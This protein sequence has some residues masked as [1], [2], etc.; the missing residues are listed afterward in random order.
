VTVI[1]KQ[2]SARQSC[3]SHKE[4]TSCTIGLVVGTEA[5]IFIFFGQNGP[6]MT[7]CTGTGGVDT[8]DMDGCHWLDSSI[9]FTGQE[10]WFN[11]GQSSAAASHWRV[12]IF[13]FRAH[14]QVREARSPPL[15]L[16]AGSPLAQVAHHSTSSI[17]CAFALIHKDVANASSHLSFW[18]VC[19]QLLAQVRK[20]MHTSLR[21]LPHVAYVIAAVGQRA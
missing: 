20:C 8:K 21:A 13:V 18:R 17:Y 3:R 2:H 4:C 9:P 5:T 1:N 14:M 12:S 7:C 10:S 16:S 6:S 19:S 15:R 11:G